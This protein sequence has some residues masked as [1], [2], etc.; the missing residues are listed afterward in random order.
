MR[1]ERKVPSSQGGGC[2][3]DGGCVKSVTDSRIP[4]RGLEGG[5]R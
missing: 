5:V 3:C 4:R 2:D 1:V